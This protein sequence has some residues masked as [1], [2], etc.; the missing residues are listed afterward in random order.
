MAEVLDFFNKT[1][2]FSTLKN[3]K[4][5]DMYCY[6]FKNLYKNKKEW[7]SKEIIAIKKELKKMRKLFKGKAFY[8]SMKY[9]TI[10]RYILYLLSLIYI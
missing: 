1:N 9:F 3:F 8:L 4:F 10:K 6:Q 2:R 7:T 5:F